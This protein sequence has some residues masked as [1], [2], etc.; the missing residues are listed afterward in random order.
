MQRL[1]TKIKLEIVDADM[2][3]ENADISVEIKKNSEGSPNYCTLNIYNISQNTYNIINDKANEIRVYADIDEKGYVLIFEG[4][5]RD[6]VKWKKAKSTVAKT[7]R[8]T[9][10]KKIAKKP[11]QVHY[12]SP[13]ILR[14][15]DDGNIT[16][17]IQLQDGFKNAYINNHYQ[18]SYEGQVSNRQI[19]NDILYYVKRQTTL[20]IGITTD[21]TEKI[22]PKGRIIKGSLAS[23]LKQICATGNCICDID[24]NI[25]NIFQK[26]QTSDV[27]GYYL[28]GGICPRPE[29]NADKE[30]SIDAP[31][32]PSVN[33]GAFVKLDFEDIDG[34][35]PIKEIESKIDNFGSSYETKLTL[36]VE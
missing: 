31:F 24:N 28:H 11:I 10:R 14:S 7:K 5:L 15:Q 22:F 21:L 3:I 30:I 4:V 13:P 34:I 25:I 18:Q 16:T 29:F 32:L 12:N 19:L 36:K 9:K 20:G 1:Y 8:K 27:Y 33:I 17:T 6:I 2:I 35:Y 26:N 23:V